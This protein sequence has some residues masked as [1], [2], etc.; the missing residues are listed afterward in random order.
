MSSRRYRVMREEV[1]ERGRVRVAG[2]DFWNYFFRLRRFGG[3]GRVGG[4][5][6]FLE[7]L[8]RR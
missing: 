3:L 7:D 4:S 2:V 8:G 6:D 5:E 1:G